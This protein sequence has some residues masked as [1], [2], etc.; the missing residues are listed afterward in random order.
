V[1]I[2]LFIYSVLLCFVHIPKRFKNVNKFFPINFIIIIVRLLHWRSVKI[3]SVLILCCNSHH[4]Q[5]MI[6]KS[7]FFVELKFIVINFINKKTSKIQHLMT[8]YETHSNLIIFYKNSYSD[9]ERRGTFK[10]N[11]RNIFVNKAI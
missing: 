2:Y 5:I 7:L 8:S 4:I 1:E 6:M 3:D 9:C 10:E 11:E